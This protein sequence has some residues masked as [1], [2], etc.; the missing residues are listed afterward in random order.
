MKQ[1]AL[2]APTVALIVACGGSAVAL[3]PGQW[4][5]TV[6]FKSIEVPGAPEAAV[7]QMRALMGQ[8]QTNSECM[9][10]QEAANPTGGLVNPGG[11]AGDC[12][13]TE[14]TFT[15]GTI[16]V[17]GACTA[18]GRGRMQMTLE[19]SY[20]ATTMEAQISSEVQA[21]PG[22]QGPQTI[23]MSGTMTGRRTGDC[24]AS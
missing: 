15:G 24:P 9:T 11:N 3:Q 7:A 19:G 8:P 21:P 17:R 23:R 18:A 10:P 13:F 4:E 14:N 5:T 20:T 2:L 22:T 1:L 16:R 6:Q 12:Q